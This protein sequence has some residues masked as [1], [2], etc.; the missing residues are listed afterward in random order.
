MGHPPDP[1]KGKETLAVTTQPGG[2]ELTRTA[3]EWLV[4]TVNGVAWPYT[5]VI[6][7]TLGGSATAVTRYAYTIANQQ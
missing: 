1:R 7:Q 4:Q 6:T 3:T 2:S 5:N